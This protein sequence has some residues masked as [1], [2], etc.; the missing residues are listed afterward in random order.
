M[1]S[2]AEIIAI[3]N[4]AIQIK[5]FMPGFFSLKFKIKHAAVTKYIIVKISEK[6]VKFINFKMVYTTGIIKAA[7]VTGSP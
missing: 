7:N 6:L 4:T 5:I 1:N 2:K 3:A